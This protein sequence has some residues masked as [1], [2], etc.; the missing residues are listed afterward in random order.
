MASDRTVAVKDLIVRGFSQ[1]GMDHPFNILHPQVMSQSFLASISPWRLL[2]GCGAGKRTKLVVV[3][4]HVATGIPILIATKYKLEQ[5]ASL[6]KGA[7]RD[8]LFR[9]GLHPVSP[10]LC[11]CSAFQVSGSSFQILTW[12][13]IQRLQGIRL[14][15]NG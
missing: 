6:A 15:P 14:T 1:S 7:G 8:V 2:R 9:P 11:R 13:H 5:Q 3:V 12:L 10:Y 4:L